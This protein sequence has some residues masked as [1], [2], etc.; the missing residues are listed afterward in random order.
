MI[1]SAENSKAIN[2]DFETFYVRG[3][4]VSKSRFIKELQKRNGRVFAYGGGT[5]WTDGKEVYHKK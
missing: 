1:L 5:I 2:T 3:K 4:P